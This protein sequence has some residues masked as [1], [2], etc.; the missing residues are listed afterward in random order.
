MLGRGRAFSNKQRSMLLLPRFLKRPF[1]GRL[2]REQPSSKA[3]VSDLI[4]ELRFK[5]VNNSSIFDNS[6][7]ENKR[8]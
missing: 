8:P 5:K 3:R 7:L 4:F 6:L 2:L 1:N